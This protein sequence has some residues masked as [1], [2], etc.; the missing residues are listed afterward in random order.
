MRREGLMLVV[1]L[2]HR[3]INTDVHELTMRQPIMIR[4]WS[5]QY[6][7][8]EMR[9]VLSRLGCG[10]LDVWILAPAHT[11]SSA[12]FRCAH[13]LRHHRLFSLGISKHNHPA[14]VNNKRITVRMTNIHSS[15]AKRSEARF[16]VELTVR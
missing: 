3:F 12:A 8:L 4:V 10:R 6:A 5:N 7:R 2:R 11:F 16:F 9:P 15:D 13:F 14:N 1:A